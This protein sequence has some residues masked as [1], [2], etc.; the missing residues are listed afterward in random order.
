MMQNPSEATSVKCT[1][2]VGLL[3]L[4][5][6]EAF[7]MEGTQINVDCINNNEVQEYMGPGLWMN[8]NGMIVSDWSTLNLTATRD[9][10]GNYTCIVPSAPFLPAVIFQVVVYCK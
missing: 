8:S 4:V 6:N 3:S 10:A 1:I 7:Y 5:G 2:I 9:L